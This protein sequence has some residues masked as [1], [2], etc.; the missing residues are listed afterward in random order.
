MSTL[1]IMLPEDKVY[2]AE[3]WRDNGG[4]F[5]SRLGIALAYA[6][7]LNALIIL[8]HFNKYVDAYEAEILERKR[9]GL[10]IKRTNDNKII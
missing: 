6:D 4:G 7:P 10:I 1:Q 2:V 8:T 3:A 5:V 9:R